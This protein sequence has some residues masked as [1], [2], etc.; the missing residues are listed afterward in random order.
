MRTSDLDP[1]LASK[2]RSNSP[3]HDASPEIGPQRLSLGVLVCK[4][5]ELAPQF[6]GG[7]VAFVLS[8]RAYCVGPAR[9]VRYRDTT[10]GLYTWLDNEDMGSFSGDIELLEQHSVCLD[11][12][13]PPYVVYSTNTSG[14]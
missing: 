2:G 6:A 14:I 4:P 8:P 3:I 7:R 11:G 9:R 5:C 13:P 10:L 1:G 12:T